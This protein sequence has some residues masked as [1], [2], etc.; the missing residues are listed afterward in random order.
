MKFM[1]SWKISPGN[2]KPA[3][4]RFLQSGVAMPD[5]LTLIGRWHGSG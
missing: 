2:H 1:I 3:G 4:E 5:G